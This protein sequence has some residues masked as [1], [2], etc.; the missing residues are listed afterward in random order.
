[1]PVGK[2][3]LRGTTNVVLNDFNGLAS[4]DNVTRKN[5]GCVTGIGK[6]Y[7]RLILRP[8]A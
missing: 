2:H 4:H 7:Q 8:A 3:F 5:N 1:M 6:Q